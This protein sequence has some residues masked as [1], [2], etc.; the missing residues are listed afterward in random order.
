M[1]KKLNTFMWWGFIFIYFELLYKIFILGNVLTTN[2][3]MILL[4]TIP[5]IVIFGTITSIF[6]SKVNKVLNIIFTFVFLILFLA[7]IVYFNFYNS[8]FSF[9]SLTAG[10]GQVMQFWEMILKVSH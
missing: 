1:K 8:I 3:L 5:W 6:N 10:T 7:Q 2:T 9:Y 4:F